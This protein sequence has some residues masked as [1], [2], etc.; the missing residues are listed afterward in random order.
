M[1]RS[2]TFWHHDRALR[3]GP[4]LRSGLYSGLVGTDGR[5]PRRAEAAVEQFR[6]F[7]T[8]PTVLSAS[9]S[10]GRPRSLRAEQ[11]RRVSLTDHQEATEAVARDHAAWRHYTIRR[12][13]ISAASTR[14]ALSS[15]DRSPARQYRK[16][17]RPRRPEI[18]AP[19]T[20][21]RTVTPN[22]RF[23]R[24]ITTT[25]SAR[26]EL[27]AG[28]ELRSGE[29]L[30]DLQER[31]LWRTRLD[32]FHQ[33]QYQVGYQFE[34]RLNDVWT[35]LAEP[36]FWPRRWAFNYSNLITTLAPPAHVALV[37]SSREYLIPTQ[38]IIR[39]VQSRPDQSYAAVGLDIRRRADRSCAA[40]DIA[41]QPDESG[42]WTSV[43][44]LPIIDSQSRNRDRP[45]SIYRTRSRSSTSGSSQ[46]AC[47]AIMC[48]ARPQPADDG[49]D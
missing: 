29:C 25:I 2:D 6:F 45:A 41:D 19:A 3:Q 28:R 4:A 5:L 47:G 35:F 33:E 37:R 26:S 12:L 14:K 40:H 15:P 48:T 20:W 27:C 8:E 44:S 46:R 49:T 22:S 7:R 30:S 24:A 23:S 18:I 21:K 43:P 10:S 11:S 36:P 38:S 16:P 1:K 31:L 39:P 17:E 32:K 34:R 42:L 13:S 9:T